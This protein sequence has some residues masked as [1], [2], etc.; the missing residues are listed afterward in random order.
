VRTFKRSFL[1]LS[2][3]S[4]GSLFRSLEHRFLFG[5]TT[6]IF[7]FCTTGIV[8]GPALTSQDIPTMIQTID[9]SFDGVWSQY[10]TDVVITIIGVVTRFNARFLYLVHCCGI[11]RDSA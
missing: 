6:I 2:C 10:K 9:P 1:A 11:T 7:I 8:L 4:K 3:S 5:I